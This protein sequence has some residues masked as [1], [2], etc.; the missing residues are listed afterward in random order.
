[1]CL[2]WCFDV[3]SFDSECFLNSNFAYDETKLLL[4]N[5]LEELKQFKEKN[6]RN[7]YH[8]KKKHEI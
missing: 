3:M 4:C 1:M 8:R 7:I 5:Y 6:A 2:F